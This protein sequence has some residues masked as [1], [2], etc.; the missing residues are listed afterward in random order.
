MLNGVDDVIEKEDFLKYFNYKY[1]DNY[2]WTIIN[3][4]KDTLREVFQGKNKKN[5]NQIDDK[6]WIVVKQLKLFLKDNNDEN[7]I[8]ILKE[9]YY[10]IKLKNQEYFVKLEDTLWNDDSDCLRIFL[11]FYGNCTSLKILINSKIDNFYTPELIKWIIYQISFGLYILHTNNIIHN[12]IKP[13]NILIDSSG[14]ITICD[15]GSMADKNSKSNSYTLYYSPP[16]FLNNDEIIRDEKSDIWSLGVTILELF[17]KKNLYFKNKNTPK[18]DLVQLN[19]IF[20]KFGIQNKSREEMKV[21]IE[22][23]KNYEKYKFKNEEIKKIT[24]ILG[25]E[26]QDKDVSDALD[27]ISNLLVINPKKR[28]SISQVLDSK[29]LSDYKYDSREVT[30]NEKI[31][32]FDKISSNLKVKESF[33]ELIKKLK[34]KL[35]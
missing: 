15:F 2:E 35:E 1:K 14:G 28:Y 19:Y 34:S 33:I 22:D 8:H 13:S 18:K 23:E 27:L 9:I 24:K 17:L 7:F 12:D 11:I 4:T 26:N 29:Y 6:N 10:L 5:T 20:S 31:E 25:K 3:K 32:D 16:E 21:I 30:I